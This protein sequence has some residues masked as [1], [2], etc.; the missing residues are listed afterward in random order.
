VISTA[1]ET[2]SVL[3]TDLVGSTAMADRVGPAAAE[4]LRAE[5]F[6][7]L[8]GALERT[9]GREVKNLGDGLMVVFDSAAQS[10]ACAL[11]MQQAVEARN[12][13]A[14]EQLGVRI[15]VSVGDTTVEDGDYF[16]EPVVESARLCAHAVGGQIVVNALVRQLAGSRDGNSF[17]SLGDLELK[18]ISEPVPAFELQWEPALVTGIPLPERLRGLP[19][20]AYVGRVAER[21]RMGELWGQACEGSLRL[22]LISGEAGVGKTRL[23]THL[24]VEAHGQGATVLYG[25]CDEDL[26]VPYQPWAQALRHFVAEAPRAVLRAHVERH[27]GDLARLVPDLGERVPDLPSPRQSD[28]ETERYLLYAAA[29][30]LLEGAGEQEPLLLILDDLQWADGPTLSLLR[31]V[32]TAGTS[33][34]VMVVGAYRDSDLSRGHPLAALLAD[35]HREQGVERLKLTGLEAGDVLALMESAA[36]HEMDEEGRALA[37]E[38]ARETAG[39]PFFAG[40]LLRH[41]AESGATVQGEG[42]RWEIVGDVAD[43]GLPQSV[44][45]VVGRRVE[46]L[47]SDARAALSAAAVIG[48]DFDLGLL[49]AVVELPEARLLDLLDGAVAA[50]LLQES[51]ERAGRFTFTHALVE[52]TL[53]EDLGRTRRARLHQLIAE[54]LEEQCGEDPGERLGE[55]AAHWAA[56]VVSSDT[57]KALHYARRAA[58]R[59]L[60]QLAPDEAV[61]WYRQA[62]ELHAQAAGGEGSERCELLIG[63]GEAQRQIGNPAFRQTLLDAAELARTEHDPALLAAVALGFAGRQGDVGIIDARTI[64]LLEEA[65]SALP[66]GGEEALRSG[67]LAR[68][69]LEL[70]YSDEIDRREEVSRQ[71]VDLARATGNSTV[72]GYALAAR[73]SALLGP[74]NLTQRLAAGADLVGLADGESDMALSFEG[75]HCRLLDMLDTGQAAAADE[76]IAVLAGLADRLRRPLYTLYATRVRAGWTLAKGDYQEGERLADE[77]LS[78]GER[79]NQPTT[80]L[81]HTAHLSWPRRDQGRHGELEARVRRLAEEFAGRM[82]AWRCHLAM[83]LAGMGRTEEARAELDAVTAA[84]LSAL[85]TDINWLQSLSMLSEVCAAVGDRPRARELYALLLPVRER[86]VLL[87][88]TGGCIGS[89]EHFLAL[90]AAT[91]GRPQDAEQ[92]FERA[93]DGN[94]AMR[95]EPCVAR[96]C[97][98]YAGLL[99]A[100]DRPDDSRRTAELLGRAREISDRLR[101]HGLRDRALELAERA[102]VAIIA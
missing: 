26:G 14:E 102:G 80:L 87:G 65:L 24:A 62:L 79:M 75:H 86:K 57:A 98:E 101:L 66:A 85:P 48:R 64:A 93:L 69:A 3:M 94:A 32:V 90:N 45:E 38:I 9:G 55:L 53:Y 5:H 31:H 25:R 78:L 68:L 39:N 10:L 27:G 67:L 63:L 89:V 88:R 97:L 40:E 95:L 28:P 72:L 77:A 22:V 51:A 7:L 52:H 18:G 60:E 99:S 96:T 92:H 44:R 43:L 61:R 13:R 1:T 4:S 74:G 19:A 17:Q 37:R 50:S 59:A 41:L 100:G 58:E 12:R 91:A 42:G 2:V 73:H 33:M 6:G 82:P 29:A 15:G 46:R 34:R 83:L 36:G 16:G 11:Q 35:L 8:R 84:G 30:G 70:Y 20:T 56:A 81:F 54:A 71:A 21:E 47:G 49:H 23:S 76:Q